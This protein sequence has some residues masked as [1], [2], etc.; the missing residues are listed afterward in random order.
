MIK[1]PVR[2]SDQRD[3]SIIQNVP[4]SNFSIYSRGS[5][6]ECVHYPMV[7]YVWILN[8]IPILNS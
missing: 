7:E 1:V 4:S 6:M 5:N 8:S 3:V 2:Y